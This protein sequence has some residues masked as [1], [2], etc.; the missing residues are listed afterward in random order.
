MEVRLAAAQT[1]QAMR[2][3]SLNQRLQGFPH[4]T[5]FFLQAGKGLGLGDQLIIKG[6][7]GSHRNLPPRH[8][9]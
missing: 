1:R 9:F 4:Q 5:R 6:K 3:L 7:R 2:A 8:D